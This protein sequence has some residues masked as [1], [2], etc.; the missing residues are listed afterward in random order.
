MKYKKGGK[1]WRKAV[2]ISE[3]KTYLVLSIKDITL[4]R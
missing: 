4:K 2:P 1:T 3:T